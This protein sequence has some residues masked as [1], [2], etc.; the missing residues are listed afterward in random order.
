MTEFEK[1]K[2]MDGEGPVHFEY[3]NS[4]FGF[5]LSDSSFTVIAK[6][7]RPSTDRL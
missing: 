1:K 3:K 4:F 5:P 6:G 2:I 7:I